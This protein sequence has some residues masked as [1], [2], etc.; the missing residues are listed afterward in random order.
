MTEEKQQKFTA[1]VRR[2][3]V[4]VYAIASAE[5]AKKKA[6]ATG[7]RIE[8]FTASELA[9]VESALTW[10]E[11]NKESKNTESPSPPSS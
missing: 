4:W 10:I 7:V 8:G 2:G 6:E 11:Q 5:L 1:K 3:L 9:D